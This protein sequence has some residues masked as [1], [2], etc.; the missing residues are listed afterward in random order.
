[1]FK[2]TYLQETPHAWRGGRKIKLAAG[3]AAIWLAPRAVP[4]PRACHQGHAV[5]ERAPQAAAAAAA[6]PLVAGQGH[7]TGSGGKSGGGGSDAPIGGN[8]RTSSSRTLA[9]QSRACVLAGRRTLQNTYAKL[10]TQASRGVGWK[11]SGT[12]QGGGKIPRASTSPTRR[13][14]SHRAGQCRCR[15][16]RCSDCA[17]TIGTGQRQRSA[18]QILNG[19][20]LKA[21]SRWQSIPCGRVQ[22]PGCRSRRSRRTR[23][24][25]ERTTQCSVPPVRAVGT[26]RCTLHR[27][28][29]QG[30]EPALGPE[31]RRSPAA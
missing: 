16:L 9:P 13:A 8:R 25:R 12:Y 30:R 5:G 28:G 23:P 15:L 20:R 19:Y 21:C 2:G 31:P 18:G 26:D 22:G 3:A 6:E 27:A 10:A 11:A 17:G 14:A 7:R 24:G 29:G 1:M 4:F